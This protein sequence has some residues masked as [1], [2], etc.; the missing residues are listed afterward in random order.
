M[1]A[2]GAL[3]TRLLLS[4][5]GPAWLDCGVGEGVSRGARGPA[6]PREACLCPR[7][8]GNFLMVLC[9]PLGTPP[10]G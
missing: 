9:F 4:T 5:T 3:D 8:L 6:Q 1:G 10:P 2:V 7:V